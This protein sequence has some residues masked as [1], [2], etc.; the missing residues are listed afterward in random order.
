MNTLRNFS[1]F[2]NF[3]NNKKLNISLNHFLN[4]KI[5]PDIINIMFN[6]KKSNIISNNTTNTI[7]KTE[8]DYDI[9]KIK[10]LEDLLF[11]P[12]TEKELEYLD[13][14]KD[15]EDYLI[16]KYKNYF[17]L[18]LKNLNILHKEH[19]SILEI[20]FN[21]I[22]SIETEFIFK[23]NKDIY[24]QLIS[25]NNTK[26]KEKFKKE[27][28]YN[29][30]SSL[31]L[32]ENST[33][34]IKSDNNSIILELSHKESEINKLM[35]EEI[36]NKFFNKDFYFFIKKCSKIKVNDKKIDI[37]SGYFYN[38]KNINKINK[39]DIKNIDLSKLSKNKIHY[40]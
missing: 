2:I 28:I 33:I 3:T 30:I 34:Y 4:S 19:N 16:N 17:S 23:D 32:K 9:N 37:I 1:I 10:K 39:K 22:Q 6:E 15:I 18:I 27:E 25:K 38:N 14:I 36:I 7:Y 21:K 26:E 29:L 5:I 31:L 13:Y 11:E 12:Y 40:K 35:I 24:N 8:Y 20:F